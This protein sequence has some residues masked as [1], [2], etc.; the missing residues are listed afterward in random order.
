MQIQKSHPTH[1]QMVQFVNQASVPLVAAHFLPTHVPDGFRL[2]LLG[3]EVE[4][5]YIICVRCHQLT[6]LPLAWKNSSV[7]LVDGRKFDQ[8]YGRSGHN[9]GDRKSRVTLLHQVGYMR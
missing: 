7:H 5:T 3:V 4:A 6:W 8:L 2:A 9:G 1:A